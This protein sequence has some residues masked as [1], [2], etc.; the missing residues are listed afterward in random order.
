[1]GEVEAEKDRVTRHE[2][3]HDRHTG[4]LQTDHLVFSPKYRGKVFEGEVAEAM[5]EVVM[6]EGKEK[7]LKTGYY[8]LYKTFYGYRLRILN[9]GY[10]LFER[11]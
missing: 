8:S 9:T 4:S 2:L 3:R 7:A 11:W 1:M 6:N 10:S 5:E